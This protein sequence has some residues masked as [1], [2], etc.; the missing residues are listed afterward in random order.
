MKQSSDY[1]AVVSFNLLICLRV[2]LQVIGCR[3]EF[4]HRKEKKD[5]KELAQNRGPLSVSMYNGI[6][7]GMKSCLR[8]FLVFASS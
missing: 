3:D 1:E 2:C 4:L 5:C 8:I 7:Y 6:S